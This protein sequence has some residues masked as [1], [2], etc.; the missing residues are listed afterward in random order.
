MKK[1]ISVAHSPDADDIF[2]YMAIKF[3]WIT[4]KK[5][6]FKN[7]ALDIETLNKNAINGEFD[8]TAISFGI[9]PKIYEDY[10]LL[11]TAVSFG[12]G[13]GPKLIKK[14]TTILKPNFKVA[15]SGENTTNALIFRIAYPKARIIYK[16]FLDI[17]QAV[18]NGEVD[19][20]VLIHESIL[21][22][23]DELCVE[24]EIWDIWQ[25]LNGENLPLPLGGM[26]IRRSLPLTNA[27]NIEKTLTNAVKIATNNKKLLSKMLIE[28]NLIRVDDKTLNNYLN[29]Y[30]N[31]KSVLMDEIQLKAVQKLFEIGYKARF[32]SDLIDV[33][34]NL[35]P[36][37]YE[38]FRFC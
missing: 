15:L 13:Y 38:D 9:Y 34:A 10:A 8:A 19:A 14:K 33:K 24:R 3:G 36:T 23:S 21:N 30:A 1:E 31:E 12:E 28:R 4:N 37:E 32:Y 26:A 27:I 17:E 7:T 18:L 22:F 2:M 16:N 5:F 20:G 11:R 35:I 29:L 6:D 25:E